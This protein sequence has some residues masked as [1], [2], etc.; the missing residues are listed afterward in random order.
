MKLPLVLRPSMSLLAVHLLLL[1]GV[2]FVGDAR[3]DTDIY[4]PLLYICLPVLITSNIVAVYWLK[5]AKLLANRLSVLYM[6]VTDLAIIAT[7][8]ALFFA[9][10]VTHFSMI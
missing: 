10:S 9:Y 3:G 4:E 8:V 7:S 6:V 2:W 1:A 5:K